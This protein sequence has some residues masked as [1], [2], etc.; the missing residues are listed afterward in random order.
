MALCALSA[1]AQIDVQGSLV[2]PFNAGGDGQ[3]VTVTPDECASY[4]G[5]PTYTLGSRLTWNGTEAWNGSDNV[6]CTLSRIKSLADAST[7]TAS[8]PEESNTFTITLPV[9]GSNVFIPTS[10]EFDAA[11]FGTSGGYITATISAGSD[12]QTIISGQ[13]PNRSKNSQELSHYSADISGLTADNQAPLTL[14]FSFCTLLSGKSHGLANITVKGR[15]MGASDSSEILVLST[16]PEDR[17]ALSRTGKITVSYT[18]RIQHG[19]GSATLKGSDGSS[20]TIEPTWGARA[21]TFSYVSLTPST[22]Y[23]ISIPEG[24]VVDALT[25]EKKAAATSVDFTIASRNKPTP[26]MVNAVVDGSL[27]Q[28]ARQKES[29]TLD[30]KNAYKLEATETMPAQFR[31]LQ[32]AIDEAPANGT[33]PY[34]IFVKNGT[35]RDPNFT[36]NSSYGTR[37]T[38]M[39]QSSVDQTTER[40]SGAINEYDSCRIVCINK[41]NIHII[42]QSRDNVII[43]TDRLDG[44]INYV[45][46]AT[47]PKRNDHS[48]VWYHIN[49]G[50][51]VEVQSTGTDMHME[52]LTVDNENWTLNSM[53]GPQALAFNISGDRAVLN[54][55]RTRSYQ[56]TYY[57]GGTYNRTFWNNSEIEGSVD[58]IY[59]ASD[60]WFE[61]CVLN[62]NR[63]SGGYIVAPNH[64]ADTRWGYV[65]NNTRITTDD[66]SNPASYSIWLGRP[67]H[68][69]PKTV[70]LHTTMELTPMDS[71]WYETMGGLPAL[72]A[73]YDFHDANGKAFSGKQAVSRSHYY[74][75]DSA[76]EQKVWGVA[77]NAITDE[78]AAEYT[79]DNV[80]SG[81][82]SYGASGYWDPRPICEAPAVPQL[83]EKNGLV[84]WT[85]D[86]YAICYAV[87]VND[88]VVAFTT[89]GEYAGTKGD[90][91]SVQAMSE[92]GSISEASQAVTCTATATGIEAI[93]CPPAAEAPAA[94]YNI[95]GQ[96]VNA[97]QRGLVISNGRKVV[98]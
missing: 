17:S 7:N 81:D 42:G 29:M 33:E 27:T 87:S 15:I 35:Y 31:T 18:A 2:W 67:W 37:Y 20:V 26:R 68:E 56:D 3:P 34:I 50:A 13:T 65:F 92:Y 93:A 57:N 12:S 64:P 16:S 28:L 55:V 97:T 86:D 69:K 89:S 79:I 78:E 24:Y 30:G 43:S 85:P 36:F 73:V 39:T 77:K 70:Y 75:T 61:N 1:M 80:L 48:R 45:K 76:T 54:N 51:C 46:D 32:A 98:R 19:T 62:I 91:V 90:S 96:R 4:F 38:D 5:T 11:K 58:F 14:S 72:W 88:N 10:V 83:T 40:I 44:G 84:T 21:L 66:V 47:N 8:A 59:G 22:I 23:T 74:Y 94:I 82:K 41:P 52:N 60:V 53:E 6:A 95:A 63:S 71:L 9:N 25:G 49:A